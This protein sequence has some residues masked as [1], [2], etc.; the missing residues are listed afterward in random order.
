M[1]EPTLKPCPF[2][3]GPAKTVI[4]E[5]ARM[6][7]CAMCRAQIRGFVDQAVFDKWNKRVSND[8]VEAREQC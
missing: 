6:V 2:C 5:G 8:P 1:K 7:W 3:G 4:M